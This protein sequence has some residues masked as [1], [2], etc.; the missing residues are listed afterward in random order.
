MPGKRVL[1]MPENGNAVTCDDSATPLSKKAKTDAG[2]QV[3]E[4]VLNDTGLQAKEK[5]VGT[6]VRNGNEVSADTG[7]QADKSQEKTI[8]QL[9][10]QEGVSADAGFQT[11]VHYGSKVSSDAGL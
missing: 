2:P 6:N 9:Q 8:G 5:V 4:R 7:S 3:G 11:D 1:E 10:L